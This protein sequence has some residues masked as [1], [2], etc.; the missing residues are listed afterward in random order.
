MCACVHVCVC[1]CMC[2]CVHV[3]MCVCV[4]VHVRMCTCV[5]VC[6]CACVHV[7]MCACVHVCMCACV[8]AG[9]PESSLDAVSINHTS[10]LQ[11]TWYMHF[12][13]KNNKS[14]DDIGRCSGWGRLTVPT[15]WVKIG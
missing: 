13:T 5:H 10:E 4:C 3:C 2:A 15:G 11:L 14:C 8:H 6:M 1:V 9:D 7:C 12:Q